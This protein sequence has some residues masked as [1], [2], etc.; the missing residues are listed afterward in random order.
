MQVVDLVLLEGKKS[1]LEL[2]ICFSLFCFFSYSKQLQTTWN[3]QQ[4]IEIL[5][6]NSI[7]FYFE[8]DQVE[9]EINAAMVRAVP[10]LA[11]F[12]FF[13]FLFSFFFFLFGFQMRSEMWKCKSRPR[14]CRITLLIPFDAANICARASR[15]AFVL[16]VLFVLF[17][18]LFSTARN[19]AQNGASFGVQ[20]FFF[21][22][23]QQKQKKERHFF[24]SNCPNEKV[25]KNKPR[26]QWHRFRRTIS[27]R[28][29][30]VF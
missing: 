3:R 30:F 1:I 16:F 22:E 20:V 13:F 2:F 10:S 18:F 27:M 11:L 5:T 23:F 15:W 17:F 14:K 9:L 19:G 24:F 4:S 25:E 7:T 28:F 29:C 26:N 12:S 6:T 21:G 8:M